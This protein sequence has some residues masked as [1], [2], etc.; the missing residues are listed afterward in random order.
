MVPGL[1]L[2]I[3]TL[4]RVGMEAVEMEQFLLLSILLC[5]KVLPSLLGFESIGKLLAI[6]IMGQRVIANLEEVP[7]AG[8]E[9]DSF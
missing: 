2:F 9:L 6:F 3:N 4:R 5:F 7:G 1:F 8:K